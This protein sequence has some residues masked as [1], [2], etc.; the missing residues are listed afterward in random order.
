[1]ISCH[2]CNTRFS[3][4]SRLK[5]ANRLVIKCDKCESIYKIKYKSFS[6]ITIFLII[7]FTPR[8]SL[9]FPEVNLFISGL[10]SIISAIILIYIVFFILSYLIEYDEI[11][12]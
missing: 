8:L 12:K 2:N 11:Y 10:I 4:I 5:S 7:T 6:F 9:I 1:M 3:F